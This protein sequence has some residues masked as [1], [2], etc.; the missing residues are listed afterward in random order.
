MNETQKRIQ[1]YKDA[2]PGL[3]E[4]VV[5][6]ALL[7]V[8]SACMMTSATFAW[9]T[10]S[11]SPEVSEMS[12]TVAANGNLEIALVDSEGN[13]PAES[14]EG[15]SSAAQG[16][17]ASNLTWGNLI[18]LSD[19]TYGLENIAL[20]PALLSDYN[21][22][23]YPLYGATYGQD[24]RVIS[25]SDRYEFATWTETSAGTKYFAAGDKSTYGVR[26]IAS[27]KYENITGNEAMTEMWKAVNDAYD[28]AKEV[29]LDMIEGVTTVDKNGTITCIDALEGMVQIFAQEKIDNMLETTDG[30]VITADYSGYVTY[31]YRMMEEFMT[32]LNY[33]GEALLNLANLQAYAS[34]SSTSTET[35]KSVDELL[36]AYKKGTLSSYDGVELESLETFYSNYTTLAADLNGKMK[37][38]AEKCD[39]DTVPAASR[40]EVLWSDIKSVVNH[41]VNVNTTTLEGMEIGSMGS[42][43]LGTL[44]DI[45]MSSS[46][47]SVVIKD[48]ILKDFEQRVGTRMAD[49]TVNVSVYISISMSGININKTVKARVTTTASDSSAPYS[50]VTDRLATENMDTG[51]IQGGDA[52]AK[53]TYGMA[54]DLWAR[55]NARDMVLTLEGTTITTPIQDTCINKEGDETDLYIMTTEDGEKEVY[56]LDDEWYYADSHQLVDETEREGATFAQKMTELVIG[57]QG[58]NRVWE[59][60]QAMLDAGL[61]EEDSTTQGSGSCFVFYANP[62]EQTQILDLLKSFTVAFLDENGN[63]LGSASLNTDRYYAING[64]VTVPLEMTS[65]TTYEDE[66]G[67][68][69]VGITALNPN[70]PT[71]ITAIVY[72]NGL[73]LEN[74]NVLASGEIQGQLNI[75]FG[76]SVSLTSPEDRELQAQYRTI[77]AVA[78]SDNQTSSTASSPISFEYDGTAKE[79]TVNLTVAG[80]QPEKINGFFVRSINDTQGTRGDVEAFTKNEDGTW[81]AKF[82]LTK[83]GSY[84][85]RSLIVDGI[86]YTLD[87]FPAVNISG[88]TIS[89]VTTS[90][91]TGVHMTADSSLNVEVTAVIDTAPELMPSQVRAQ[92]RDASGKE[93]NALM[94]YNQEN[95]QWTGTASINVS[96]TYTLEYLVM[97]GEYTEIPDQYKT[98]LII[99]LGMT[100]Q[101][102][103]SLSPTEFEFNGED[104][105]I[106]IQAKI[107]DNAGT[108][109]KALEGVGLYYHSASSSLDQNGM[110]AGLKWNS[111]TGY[112]EG[113]LTMTKAGRYSFDRLQVTTESGSSEIRTTSSAPVFVAMPPDPPA[114]N[115]YIA[116]EYQVDLNGNA[117]LTVGLL[118]AESATIGAK[119]VDLNTD[120]EYVV[121]GTITSDYDEVVVD[122]ETLRAYHYKF[123]IPKNQDGNQNGEW[124]LTELYFQDVFVNGSQITSTEGVIPDAESSYVIDVSGKGGSKGIY[125]YVVSTLTTEFLPGENTY[126]NSTFAFGGTK[127]NPTGSF[128]QT[129]TVAPVSLKVVDWD[130]R[131]L[132]SGTVKSVVWNIKHEGKSIDYGGYTGGTTPGPRDVSMAAGTDDD[133]TVTTYTAEAQTFQYAGEYSSTVTITLADGQTHIAEKPKITVA[134]ITPTVAITGI[135][136]TGTVNYDTASAGGSEGQTANG[137]TSGRGVQG[138]DTNSAT[139]YIGCEIQESGLFSKKYYHEYTPSQV[140]ITADNLGNASSARLTFTTTDNNGTVHMYKDYVSDMSNWDPDT[141]NRID[142]YEWT[143]SGSTVTYYIGDVNG[144]LSGSDTKTAAGTLTATGL[145]LYYNSEPYTVPVTITINNQY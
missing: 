124:K 10:L 22:N 139:V 81:T 96:G 94:S 47:K 117:A 113:N 86:E 29:Y 108:E 92:F 55:T 109:M 128:M 58:E 26:A 134:S 64:K 70:E 34:G 125:A 3:K 95:N 144:A 106:P 12:T 103:T 4:R 137:H 44:A 84:L 14:K 138:Y 37:T 69:C 116:N 101:V 127:D 52:T 65:G 90:L 8:M 80:E 1:A 53:D 23:R 118:Y 51:S 9:I 68:E 21:R 76:S 46:T 5:A 20:R 83:P 141:E 112:Y 135:S 42:K 98:T 73:R 123:T 63:L 130:G 15:D 129:H 79:V 120:K 59:Q 122:G 99:N 75:Q 77:T 111:A 102:W 11:R 67:N 17:V 18:N 45:A 132:Q 78:V 27:V 72:L 31:F 40:P 66:D 28:D 62:T 105:T 50:S 97:D 43:D 25:T 121:K 30:V 93:F 19:P 16:I 82:N 13:V 104:M 88:L 41:L 33:E 114:F 131:A 2:L 38:L 61:I 60:W 39:P 85:M 143:T 145:V 71:R 36:T 35:F 142:Y 100:T 91:R 89:S 48:G 107:R 54:I 57:Y 115:A 49:R 6:V 56:K 87:S 32:I 140:S 133:G 24:G 74:Q 7:L 110:Y 119:I 126:T 136:P